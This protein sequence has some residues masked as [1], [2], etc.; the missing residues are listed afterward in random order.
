[1]VLE[2]RLYKLYSLAPSLLKQKLLAWIIKKEGG[3]M[4]SETVRY[5]Y[6]KKYNIKIGYGTYGGCFKAKN[7]PA[8]VVFGNYCSIAP[9]IR[10]FRAN[11]PKTNFTSHPILYNP[12]AGYVKQDRLHRPPLYIGHDVWIGEWAIILP[13]VNTIGNGAIIGAGTVVTKDVPPY[14][15]VAG[16]PAKVIGKRFDEQTIEELERLQWWNLRKDEL[17]INI[18]KYQSITLG[19]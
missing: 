3:Y 10:I 4:Y 14:T 1:M 19:T 7:I 13:N 11:H 17:I 6:E 15:I 9:D 2:P 5:I 18:E 12:V 8:G 16:N